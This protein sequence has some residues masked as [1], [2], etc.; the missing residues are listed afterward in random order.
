MKKIQ[1]QKRKMQRGIFFLIK[2]T[3]VKQL[4]DLKG[5]EPQS[6]ENKIH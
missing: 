1:G 6:E 2:T 4:N 5:M 3:N